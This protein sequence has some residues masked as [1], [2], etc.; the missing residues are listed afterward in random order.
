M[1]ALTRRRVIALVG[2]LVAPIDL[3]GDAEVRRYG[4]VQEG[5]EGELRRV[6][7]SLRSGAVDEV[8]LLFRLLGHNESRAIS[9]LCR[10]LGVTV[11]LLAGHGEARR[12]LR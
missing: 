8:W 2:G 6:L 3:P 10:R 5:G 9:R 7:R 4:S 12:R 11:R 1:A